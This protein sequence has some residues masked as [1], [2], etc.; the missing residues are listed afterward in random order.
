VTGDASRRALVTNDDGFTGAG[1]GALG[2]TPALV[3]SWI[4]PGL[5]T[6]RAPRP[7]APFG[8]VRAAVVENDSGRLQMELRETREVLPSDSGRA[9]VA[10]GHVAVC[11]IRG[12]RGDDQRARRRWVDEGS[13]HRRRVS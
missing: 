4:N 3:V 6:G 2:A 12:V 9:L 10:D 11:T 5:N 13:D 8:V 7:S 1:L